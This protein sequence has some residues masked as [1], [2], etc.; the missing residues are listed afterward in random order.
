MT[1]AT[2]SPG[3][4]IKLI[5]H[6]QVDVRYGHDYKLQNT[7]T[8]FPRE[9]MSVLY[10]QAGHPFAPIIRVNDAYGV[11]QFQSVLGSCTGSG[12]NLGHMAWWD[13]GLRPTRTR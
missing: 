4:V 10:P 8:G 6:H 12:V 5:H 9:G 11:V 7:V 3:G 1:E 2:G 13:F